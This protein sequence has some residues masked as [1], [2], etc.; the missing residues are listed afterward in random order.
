[1]QLVGLSRSYIARIELGKVAVWLDVIER[2]GEALG[3]SVG[4]VIRL[5]CSWQNESRM[6]ASTDS[7]SSRSRAGCATPDGSSAAKSQVDYGRTHAWIDLLA[8]DPRTRT[9]LIV[10]IKTRLEDLG[11]ARAPARMVR[12]PRRN[13]GSP[14]RL[15]TRAN[16]DMADR[17]GKRGSRAVP[18]GA[19]VVIEG[20]FAGR[21][22]HM[23]AVARNGAPP[24]ARSVALVDPHSRRAEWLIRTR[25]DGRR[26][27]PPDEGDA[28]AARR[29]EAR[30]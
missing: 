14:P 13:G 7:V 16:R 3:M 8:F 5:P 30:R 19:L 12:A 23:L 20:Q 28:A 11:R 6:T 4:L 2:I 24:V 15:V 21:A 9:L 1:L 25:L 18:G 26:S 29:L 27:R 10:E 17:V 22:G